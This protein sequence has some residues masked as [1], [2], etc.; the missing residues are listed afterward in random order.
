MLSNAISSWRCRA[1]ICL[2]SCDLLRRVASWTRNLQSVM[3][4]AF[5]PTSNTKRWCDLLSYAD[6]QGVNAKGLLTHNLLMSSHNGELSKPDSNWPACFVFGV[7]GSLSLGEQG[8]LPHTSPIE[9]AVFVNR[10]YRW[11]LPGCL[12]KYSRLCCH[13]HS[14]QINRSAYSP[15]ATHSSSS[16]EST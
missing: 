5:K 16:R 9:E 10:S 3:Y 12:P 2:T 15:S 13:H 4:S 1:S 14:F 6:H 11:D 8:S 7:L